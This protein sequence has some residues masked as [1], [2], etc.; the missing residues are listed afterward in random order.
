MKASANGAC[1]EELKADSLQ[2]D[3][4]LFLLQ[5]S[6]LTRFEDL[7]RLNFDMRRTCV[8]KW[9]CISVPGET[10]KRNRRSNS[11]GSCAGASS[12]SAWHCWLTSRLRV[13][14]TPCNWLNPDK[15]GPSR[16]SYS[17][18]ASNAA[19]SKN[20]DSTTITVARRGRNWTFKMVLFCLAVLCY[21]NSYDGEFVFD[22]TEAIVNNKDVTRALRGDQA[23]PLVQTGTNERGVNKDGFW[24]LIEND[25]WG[26]PLSSNLSH[27]SWR[28]LTTLTF[29]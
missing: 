4:F 9:T 29:R 23:N 22:D 28:P 6:I 8:S 24:S 17:Y 14:F 3:Q 11:T 15:N 18:P 12:R 26:T 10:A 16:G 2:V 1:S 13:L 27:K 21:A 25:F 7:W 19:E 5:D 20:T